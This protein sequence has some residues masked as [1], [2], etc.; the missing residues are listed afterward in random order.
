MRMKK[1]KKKK[2]QTL[3]KRPKNCKKQ[4]EEENVLNGLKSLR[5]L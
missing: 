3:F 2:F 4:K 5:T 1:H